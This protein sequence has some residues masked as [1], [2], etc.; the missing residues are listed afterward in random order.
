MKKEIL[1]VSHLRL[2]YKYDQVLSDVSFSAFAGEIVSVIGNNG[3]GKTILGEILSQ[4]VKE[5]S[6][7][8]VF[9]GEDQ[10]RI[11][12]IPEEEQ[13]L[14]NM[15]VAENVLIGQESTMNCYFKRSAIYNQVQQYF[16]KYHLNISS[17]L[18]GTELTS[19][20]K[21]IVMLVRQLIQIPELLVI[22]GILDFISYED[23]PGIIKILNDIAVQGTAIIYL[24]YNYRLAMR[25]SDR[26]LFL[27]KGIIVYEMEH[28]E[29][30]EEKISQVSLNFMKEIEWKSCKKV[31]CMDE[32]VLRVKDLSTGML[33]KVSFALRRGELVGM[34]GGRNSGIIEF[35]ECLSGYRKITH[36]E[37]CVDGKLVAIR[38][39]KTAIRNG[40][41]ICGDNHQDVLLKLSESI[42]MNLSLSI[43]NRISRNG[44][45]RRKFED[46]IAKEYCEKFDINYHISARL[47]EMNYASVSKVAIA[48]CMVSNPK[49]LILN[50]SLRGLDEAGLQALSEVLNEVKKE[51]GIILIFSKVEKALGICDRIVFWGTKRREFT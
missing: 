31:E 30:V 45:I 8:V 16:D 19:A 33:K 51:C 44:F 50:D 47:T 39:P 35:A 17:K 34:I 36:G 10:G 40:I 2:K 49:V 46:I 23:I 41:R 15:S 13:I 9:R 1:R 14:K 12:Y 42:K 26:L 48:S 28:S 3:V 43:L 24:T 25:I 38:N 20:Q 5:D 11:H 32:E 27:Q 18:K 7:S 22:D 21:R 6:G 29:F 4:R 37:I